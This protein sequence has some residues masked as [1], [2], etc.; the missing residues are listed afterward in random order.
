MEI[1]SGAQLK[2]RRYHFPAGHPWMAAPKEADRPLRV[3]CC[4][5]LVRRSARSRAGVAVT[6]GSVKGIHQIVGP[7][8]RL[9]SM[10]PAYCATLTRADRRRPGFGQLRTFDLAGWIVDNC[11][12]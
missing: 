2:N 10:R 9:L 8:E 11:S 3:A 12:A 1:V 5:L 6:A 4:R 7:F